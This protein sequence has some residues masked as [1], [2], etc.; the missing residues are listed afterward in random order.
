MEQAEVSAGKIVAGP[1]MMRVHSP[2]LKQRLANLLMDAAQS[3]ASIE[4]IPLQ[5]ETR[6]T[7][8]T[9][10]SPIALQLAGQQSSMKVAKT[11]LSA[12]P[13]TQGLKLWVKDPGWIYG[14]FETEVITTWLQQL[15]VHNPRLQPPSQTVLDDSFSDPL[16][17]PVQYA[18]ARCCSLLRLAQRE[19]LIALHPQD[20]GFDVL[21][22]PIPWCTEQH[23]LRLQHPTEQAII[24]KLLEFPH[25]L[26]SP[27]QVWCST[28]LS[29]VMLPWPIE[30]HQRVRYAQNWA[31]VFLQSYRECR[32]F[33]SVSQTNQPL[34][35]ARLGLVAATQRVLNFLLQDMLNLLAPRE[36]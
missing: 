26:Q 19:R 17:F 35:Q 11:M 29:S 31:E 6:A 8:G 16:L 9:F 28:D 13:P 15:T 33:G 24:Q 4:S 18:H 12:I 10:V 3:I 32:I 22:T 23:Q 25:G 1:S 20:Q 21:S 30:H 5:I 27:K 36:L 2:S 14:Q 7:M 34:S